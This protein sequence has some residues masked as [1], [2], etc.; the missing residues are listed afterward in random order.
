MTTADTLTLGLIILFLAAVV[1]CHPNIILYRA[2]KNQLNIH[3]GFFT[4]F[5]PRLESYHP[6]AFA[7]AKKTVEKSDLANKNIYFFVEHLPNL[8]ALACV[9]TGNTEKPV[10]LSSRILTNP[11]LK[12]IIAH[13]LGHIALNH[14][15]GGYHYQDELAAFQ[16]A[17]QI[18]GLELTLCAIQSLSAKDGERL[19]Q[20]L[21]DHN[22]ENKT[23]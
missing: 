7:I 19:I 13:E 10:M 1:F 16:Y 23:G 21:T 4:F 3:S 14:K 6:K 8:G 17:V 2:S 12:I 9:L 18:Y 5:F 22:F 20:D 15:G 11:H